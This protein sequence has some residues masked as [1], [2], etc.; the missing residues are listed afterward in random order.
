PNRPGRTDVVSVS[1]VRGGRGW[2]GRL[3]LRR[4]P[5]RRRYGGLRGGLVRRRRLGPFRV[6][7]ARLLGHDLSDPFAVR[8][9]EPEE[10]REV[11]RRRERERPPRRFPGDE[12]E[13]LQAFRMLVHLRPD[14]V[15][16]ITLQDGLVICDQRDRLQEVAIDLR[17]RERPGPLRVLRPDLHRP[18]RADLGDLE[19]ALPLRVFGGEGPQVALDRL[20]VEARGPGQLVDRERAPGAVQGR[21]HEGALFQWLASCGTSGFGPSAGIARSSSIGSYSVIDNRF[22]K[23]WP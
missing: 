5:G 18:L 23:V 11:P 13:L 21:F 17:G 12:A 14:H 16:Q 3:G 8:R 1:L 7:N 10:L 15:E 4:L 20:R 6:R 9:F 19:R 22:T 2:R